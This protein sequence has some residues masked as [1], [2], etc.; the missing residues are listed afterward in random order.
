[1]LIRDT[2]V[3][4]SKNVSHRMKIRIYYSVIRPATKYAYE[5]W[6]MMK[7]HENRLKIAERR[8]L[9]EIY[10]PVKVNNTEIEN[11]NLLK[12]RRTI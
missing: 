10:G 8:I 3:M 11:E 5:T 12:I 9:K 2:K 7:Q 4:K 6:T 1:M